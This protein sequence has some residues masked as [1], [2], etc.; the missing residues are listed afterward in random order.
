M[1]PDGREIPVT[2][3]GPAN[4][5]EQLALLRLARRSGARAAVVECMAIDPFL[6]RVTER[7]MI[8]ATIGVITNV[9]LDHTEVMG[10][11][12]PSIAAALANT[13]PAGGV[14]VTGPAQCPPPLPAEGRGRREPASW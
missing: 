5:R 8:R 14:L 4:I 2:R 3:R 6:Q 12:R 1:L 7:E 13:I 10:P 9:R 11:D